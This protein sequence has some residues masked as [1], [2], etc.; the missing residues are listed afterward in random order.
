MRIKHLRIFEKDHAAIK[1][2]ALK[3]GKT[4]QDFVAD[5]IAAYKGKK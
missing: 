3:A 4:I 5:L 2:L 1:M